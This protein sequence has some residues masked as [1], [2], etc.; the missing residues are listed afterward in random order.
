MDDYNLLYLKPW[1]LF[2][3]DLIYHLLKSRLKIPYHHF[4]KNTIILLKTIK[5][6]NNF[7]KNL[8]QTQAAIN[9]QNVSFISNQKLFSMVCNFM[10]KQHH[11]I[12]AQWCSGYHYCTTSFN[13]TW[14]QVLCRFK[15]CSWHVLG[16][17]WSGSLTMVPAGN[18]AKCLLSVNHN[19]KTIHHHHQDKAI[20]SCPPVS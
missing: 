4:A 11:H 3:S 20:Y 10:F 12:V 6:W 7:S 8:F 15:P 5:S 2:L 17:R 16:S 9:L 18:K 19:A 14:T 13:K 1:L